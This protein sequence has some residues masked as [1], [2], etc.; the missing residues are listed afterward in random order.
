VTLVER[1]GYG[2]GVSRNAHEVPLGGFVI[3]RL[4]GPGGLRLR[5]W[6][7]GDAAGVVVAFAAADM[8]QQ[9]DTP[10]T[11][12][13]Q[14][15]QWIAARQAAWTAGTAFSWVAAD[16]D[17]GL[18]GSVMISSLNRAHDTGWVS[19]W[20]SPA[21]R[22]RGVASGALRAVAAWAFAEIGLFRLELGHRTNNPASCAVARS[23][24]FLAEG[25]ERSKLRYG[26]TRYDVELHARLATDPA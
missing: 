4:E 25:L 19:Y 8:D 26:D 5:P 11:A 21:A 12:I 6:T 7:V 16:A 2:E 9:R 10:I 20:T 1:A 3:D 22:G 23:A 18:L 14:A 15:E 13:G 17:D 24:G